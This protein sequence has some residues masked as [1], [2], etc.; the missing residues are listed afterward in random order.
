MQALAKD[1][2]LSVYRNLRGKQVKLGKQV[3]YLPEIV[4]VSITEDVSGHLHFPVL[5]LYPE[6]MVTDFI[7]D[8]EENIS[9]KDQL[10]VI[11]AEQ[12]PW[13]HAHHYKP[14]FI[15][16]YFEADQTLP[17]D[18][19]DTSK[20]KSNKKYIKCSLESSL[21]QILQQKHHIVPQYPVLSIVSKKS[22]FRN[23]FLSEI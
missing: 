1:K 18:Q 11:F 13:D 8:W 5:I 9:L 21:L 6:F 10:A 15:E 14:E 2:K 4:D 23:S 19:K 20:S 7:Q 12:A 22:N 16:V 17:L 3:A